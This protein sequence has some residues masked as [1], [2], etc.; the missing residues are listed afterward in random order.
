MQRICHFQTIWPVLDGSFKINWLRNVFSLLPVR[1]IQMR[2]HMVLSK[3]EQLKPSQLWE[4][5]SDDAPVGATAPSQ[6]PH[7]IP[8]LH[9]QKQSRAAVQYSPKTFGDLLLLYKTHMPLPLSRFVLGILWCNRFDLWGIKMRCDREAD[10]KSSKGHTREPG[11]P[12]RQLLCSKI[13][14]FLSLLLLFL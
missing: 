9:P 11:R 13:R 7:T 10:Y 3:A 12:Q 2:H 14:A 4:P 8:Q 5:W 1:W 6:Q